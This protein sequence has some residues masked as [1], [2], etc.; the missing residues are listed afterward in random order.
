MVKIAFFDAKNYDKKFFDRTN[1]QYNF[2][3]KYFEERLSEDSVSMVDNVDAICVFVNDKLS[4][5]VIETLSKKK[6]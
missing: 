2:D 1:L 5:K 6:N 3:I 4:K